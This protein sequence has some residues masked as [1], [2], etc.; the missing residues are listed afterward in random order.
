M[1]AVDGPTTGI[2]GYS[3]P[4]GCVCNA[5]P[6][7]FP[8]HVSARLHGSRLLVGTS[9]EWIAAGLCPISDAHSYEKQDRHRG[10]DCPAVCLRTSHPT[11]RVSKPRANGKDGDEFNQ[12]REGCRIFKRVRAIGIEKAAAV[13]P[14]LLDEFLRS[15]WSLSDSLLSD[16]VHHRLALC[17]D[18]RLAIRTGLLDLHR[19]DELRS[20]V[21]AQVLHH[22]LRDEHQGAN[23]AERQEDPEASADEIDPEVSDRLHLPA[24]NPANERNRERY[25]YRRGHKVVI[26]KP[27]H[28]GEVAHGV[29]TRIS[30]PVGV[31]RKRCRCVERNVGGTYGAELLRIEW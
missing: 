10:P 20:V 17:I 25:T 30:L 5:E 6:D 4:Q 15:H 31:R 26:S 28:L 24:G 23:H 27:R 14:P 1:P 21:R 8:L 18:H 29:F 12:I 3:R 9:Q 22:A 16:G 19:L 13:G 7:F 2:G 11:Q